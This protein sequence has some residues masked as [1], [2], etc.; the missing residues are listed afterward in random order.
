[1]A[2]QVGPPRGCIMSLAPVEPDPFDDSL[3]D[4]TENWRELIGTII[5]WC[6]QHGSADAVIG[7]HVT[8]IENLPATLR[9]ELELEALR[10]VETLL[11][12]LENNP[13]AYLLPNNYR[14]FHALLDRATEAL[15]IWKRGAIDRTQI[16]LRTIRTIEEWQAANRQPIVVPPA[17]APLPDSKKPKRSTRRGDARIKIIAAL[18]EHHRRS[19]CELNLE[20]IGVNQL[21]EKAKVGKASVSRFFNKSFGNKTAPDGLANYQRACADPSTIAAALKALNGEFSPSM[22][23]GNPDHVAGHVDQDD[24]DE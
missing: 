23:F 8:A 21:A 6:R 5:R 4:G 2:G 13:P 9:P 1:M 18:T 17:D 24:D 16:E 10:N 19:N 22:L 3:L 12:G 11:V 15:P 7:D 20:T 14:E